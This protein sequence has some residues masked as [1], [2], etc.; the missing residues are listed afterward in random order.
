MI[1]IFNRPYA[2]ACIRGGEGSRVTGIVRFYCEG[3][4]TLVVAQIRGL[5]QTDSGFFGF[6]IH[7]GDNCGG[8]DYAETG[9]HYNLKNMPHPRHTGDLPNL[10]SCNGNAFLVVRTDR[11]I[12]G[13]VMGRTVVVYSRPDDAHSQPS[14]DSGQKIAC[15]LIRKV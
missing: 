7:E 4:G 6:H 1:H 11:F 8:T 10:L 12:P 3:E 5:P 15:G 2:V 14:G 13:D 9:S